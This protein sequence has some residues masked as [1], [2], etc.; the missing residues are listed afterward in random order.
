MRSDRDPYVSPD[1]PEYIRKQ[2]SMDNILRLNKGME[3]TEKLAYY[4][5]IQDVCNHLDNLLDK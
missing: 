2:F 5:A 4:K 3:A 1:L